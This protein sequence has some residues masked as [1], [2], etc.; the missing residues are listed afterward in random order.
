VVRKT[1]F[2]FIT[3]VATVGIATP[4]LAD[5]FPIIAQHQTVTNSRTLWDSAATPSSNGSRY[6]NES[7][8]NWTGNAEWSTTRR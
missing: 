4:A 6:G 1:K 2:A 5:G 7:Y 8:G 3:A